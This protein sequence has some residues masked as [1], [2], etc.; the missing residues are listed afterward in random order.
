MSVAGNISGLMPFA[1]PVRREVA[2]RCS[3]Y[4]RDALT[5]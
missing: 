3:R 4:E 2:G 1:G 5:L